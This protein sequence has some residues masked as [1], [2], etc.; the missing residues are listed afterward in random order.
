MHLVSFQG[1]TSLLLAPVGVITGL[2]GRTKYSIPLDDSLCTNFRGTSVEAGLREPVGDKSEIALKHIIDQL[3]TESDKKWGRRLLGRSKD[4]GTTTTALLIVLVFFGLSGGLEAETSLDP[5]A[6][7]AIDALENLPT[8]DPSL[9]FTVSQTR[10]VIRNNGELLG[11]VYSAA[12]SLA[13]SELSEER[14]AGDALLAYDNQ[15]IDNREEAR[16]RSLLLTAGMTPL[17]LFLYL[18]F[19]MSLR[20]AITAILEAIAWQNDAEAN[21][22]EPAET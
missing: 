14:V 9:S 20:N 6:Q 11:D 19:F 10:E 8:D 1:V 5:S 21:S 4:V 12:L 15:V 18:G 2:F 13:D 17:F 3:K 22:P 7:A 16:R